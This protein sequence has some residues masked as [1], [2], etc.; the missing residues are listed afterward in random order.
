MSSLERS[1]E[2]SRKVI[3]SCGERHQGML[4]LTNR[5][6]GQKNCVMILNHDIA[7][8][9]FVYCDEFDFFIFRE[10]KSDE[11]VMKNTLQHSKI[12]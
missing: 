12:F 6:N 4:Q 2:K 7:I 1:L 8:D 10:D 5:R 3:K 9:F 11:N